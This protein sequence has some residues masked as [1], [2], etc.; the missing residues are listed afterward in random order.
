MIPEAVGKMFRPMPRSDEALL[1]TRKKY[2]LPEKFIL[3]LGTIEPRKNISAIIE[4]YKKLIDS[5][6]NMTHSLV[7][8]GTKGWLFDDI[9]RL[10]RPL[11]RSG[12]IIFTGPVSDEERAHIYNMADIFVYPSFFEGFGLPPLE[13]MSC[14]LPVI[15]SNSSSLPEVVGQAAV[16]VD[17]NDPDEL[18]F[19]MNELLSNEDLRKEYSQKGSKRAGSFSWEDSAK[20][21]LAVIEQLQPK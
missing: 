12:K 17:P 21:T 2:G 5:D 19:F 1:R 9:M 14:G 18:A 8:A 11:V 10:S 20:K 7:V 15:V 3:F 6:K 13:A 16:S 4:A